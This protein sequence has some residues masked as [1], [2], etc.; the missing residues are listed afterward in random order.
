MDVDPWSPLVLCDP[1]RP[2]AYLLTGEGASGRAFNL[3]QHRQ[4]T[5][6]RRV[7]GHHCQT[8][9]ALLGEWARAFAFP[10]YF[11]HN[12]DAFD[13]CITDLDWLPAYCYIAIVS[14]ASTVLPYDDAAFAIFIRVL[15]SAAIAWST[16]QDG[17]WA[18][19]S[20]AFRVLF[21]TMMEQ[22]IRVRARL[23]HTGVDP[24]V[25]PLPGASDSM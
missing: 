8:T 11:G 20:I 9:Q 7:R 13:E 24:I 3:L 1:Q 16:P 4:G 18:R 10:S 21:H 22:E 17:E 6:V 23:Q 19:P 2:W 14:D 25:L 12:W 5:V 15:R